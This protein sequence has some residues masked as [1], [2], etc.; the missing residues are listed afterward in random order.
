MLEAEWGVIK[1]GRQKTGQRRGEKASLF[2]QE[3]EDEAMARFFGKR[4]DLQAGVV[5]GFDG[6][7]GECDGGEGAL[8]GGA[9]A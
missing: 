4:S 8:V 9:R 6:R 2:S 5:G 3:Q 7:A 1:A